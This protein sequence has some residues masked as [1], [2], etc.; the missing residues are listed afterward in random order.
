MSILSSIQKNYKKANNVINQISILFLVIGFGYIILTSINRNKTENPQITDNQVFLC[1]TSSENQGKLNKDNLVTNTSISLINVENDIFKTDL[2]KNQV[3]YLLNPQF[4]NLN[5]ISKCTSDNQMMLVYVDGNSVNVYPQSILNYHLVVNDTINSKPILITYSPLSEHFEVYSRK[6]KDKELIFG[7]SGL[8]YK[9]ND[10]IFDTESESLWSQFN[11]K[12]LVGNYV[13]GILEKLPYMLL[14][15]KQIIA[16]Y[17]NARVMTYKTG[18]Q[19]NYSIDPFLDYKTNDTTIGTIKNLNSEIKKKDIVIGF[20]YQNQVYAVPKNI[21]LNT[22]L[23][24]IDSN[25]QFKILPID[26]AF[27]ITETHSKVKINEYTTAYAFVWFDF[28][29]QTKLIKS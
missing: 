12:A 17:P 5:S 22:N 14:S 10:L 11:G 13:G 25:I 29:P 20:V 26:G 24:T 19:R 8:L 18:Y 3:P 15:Y 16:K 1:E 28:F 9:N 6:F 7:V 4:D 23:F 27:Q 2:V 21:A